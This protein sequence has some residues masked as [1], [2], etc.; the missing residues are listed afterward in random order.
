M[1]KEETHL[2]FVYEL[3]HIPVL[4]SRLKA[5]EKFEIVGLNYEV[6]LE[7]KRQEILFIPLRTLAIASPE[8][9]R[10][11]LEFIR[12]LAKD[13]YVSADFAFFKRDGVWLG[14]QYRGAF[15]HYFA[16]LVY[17]LAAMEQ[18]ISKLSPTKIII[19]ERHHGTDTGID[20]I[21][22]FKERLPV[23]VTRLLA[24]HYGIVFEPISLI[25]RRRSVWLSM[26]LANISKVVVRLAVGIVNAISVFRRPRH[27]KILSTDP[28]ARIEPFI[29]EMEDA[30]VIMTHRKEILVM[31]IKNIWKTRA[32][33]HHRL[34]FVNRGIRALAL[35]KS[36][37]FARAWGELGESPNISKL[38]EYK[39][40]SFWPI[41]K[42]VLQAIVVEHS[43]DAIATIESTK[44]LLTR[45]SI[46]RVLLFSSVKGYNNLIAQVAE[47]M[48]IPSVEMQHSLEI[49]EP[50]NPYA[51]LFSRYLAA[52]GSI[53]KKHYGRFGVESW[54]IV[55][56]GSPRFDVYTL[57]IAPEELEHP[58]QDMQFKKGNLTVLV[59]LPAIFLGSG[60]CDFTTYSAQTI[61]EDI[62][63]L[64]KQ[65]TSISLIL[66]PRPG[67]AEPLY[68][69]KETQALFTGDVYLGRWE[70][71]QT[72]IAL[73]DFVISGNSSVVL[74]A[75]IMHKPVLMYV[76]RT[77]DRDFDEYEMAGAVLMART[78]DELMA[79]T[80]FLEDTDN[81]TALVARAD[82]FLKKN[83]MM[84]GHSSERIAMLLHNIDENKHV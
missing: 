68:Y 46:N 33:F 40:I 37:E 16:A 17:Y 26:L 11:S 61:L 30:E 73:S 14:E 66:R 15:S 80:S 52:Y 81:R 59:V 84:D 83:F 13:W 23:D 64:Q 20:P 74:E 77:E 45:Y 43:E 2:F 10:E 24:K 22:I 39:D 7:L 34:D 44:N 53:T 51:H 67:N 19:P 21:D 6:E 60:H 31:G 36:Q 29:K 63:K 79:H 8:G 54:R 75:I 35:K 48:N 3:E 49:I 62:A 82:I 70:N 76:P 12:R 56:C 41:V 18:V 38:F 72:L 4:N 71:L 57:P 69:R 28:W 42:N 25:E 5:G 47:R 9:E 50:S 27:I 32:R 78:T 58:R 1:N 65:H 55:E